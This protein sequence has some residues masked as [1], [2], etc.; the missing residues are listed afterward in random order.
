MIE[1]VAKGL[2]RL[3]EEIV[4]VGGATTGIYMD[5]VAASEPRPTDD[6]DCVIE[7][8][9]RQG[10]Y[11]L[12]KR[13]R[14]LGFKNSMQVKA[15]VCR[16]MFQS[17]TVDVMPTDPKILGFSNRWYAEAILAAEEAVLPSKT[18]IRVFSLP[19]FI[20][21]KMEAFLN[22]GQAD[23]RLSTDLEDIV[24][25]LEG[26]A[27]ARTRLEQAKGNVLAYLRERLSPLLK[28]ARFREAVQS[29]LQ[30]TSDTRAFD[31]VWAILAGL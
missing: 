29:H 7:V 31:R 2:G 22:R 6:V 24:T 23:F 10:Y 4:F 8:A 13:L 27:D 19:Y 16:W 3:V 30:G 14:A 1:I 5:A 26:A 18:T 25:V 11:A 28:D 21:S 20:A 9:T 12:E 15:P 17:I